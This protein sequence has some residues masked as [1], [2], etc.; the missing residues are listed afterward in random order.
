M[1]ITHIPY[2]NRRVSNVNTVTDVISDTN[3]PLTSSDPRLSSPFVTLKISSVD[4]GGGG[5][6]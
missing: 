4:V 5:E 2:C 3:K 1:L 6:M